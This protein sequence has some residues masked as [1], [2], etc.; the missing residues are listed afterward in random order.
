MK[1]LKEMG[2]K[3]INLEVS[4]GYAGIALIVNPK[5]KAARQ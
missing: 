1:I 4:F 2:F 5:Y 3:R